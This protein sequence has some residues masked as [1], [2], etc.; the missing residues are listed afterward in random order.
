MNVYRLTGTPLELQKILQ[1]EFSV[2]KQYAKFVVRVLL[3]EQQ[4]EQRDEQLD[5]LWF[6]K[7]EGSYTAPIFNTRYTISFSDT[8]KM[9]LLQLAAI[10]TDIIV[11]KEPNVI[12]IVVECILS[13]A[14]VVNHIGDNECCVY[15]QALNW[16]ALNPQKEYFTVEDIYP[17]DPENVCEHLDMLNDEKW[18]CAYCHNEKCGISIEDFEKIIE[19]LCKRNV[20]DKCN[21]MYKF[22]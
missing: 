17:N 22:K 10:F 4:P 1:N 6:L 3:T 14:Q 15:Y 8:R 19:E 11:D 13:I 20:F 9:F 5:A 12:S 21:N 16:R 18:G 2:D 7:N